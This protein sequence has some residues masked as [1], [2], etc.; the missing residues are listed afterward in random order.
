MPSQKRGDKMRNA[1]TQEA[2]RSPMRYRHGAVVTKGGKIIA[3]GHNHIRTGFSGPLSAHETIVLPKH[4]Q[5]DAHCCASYTD[6]EAPAPRPGLASSYFSMHAEM[7]AIHTILR[8][9]RP[10]LARSSVQLCPTH[11]EDVPDVLARA[12]SALALDGSRSAT[13]NQDCSR[14]S[15]ASHT[16]GRV[17]AANV[18]TKCDRALVE[19]GAGR[20]CGQW[21]GNQE[22]QRLRH[23]FQQRRAEHLERRKQE[24]RERKARGLRATSSSGSCS[25]DSTAESDSTNSGTSSSGPSTPP[26]SAQDK[27]GKPMDMS[28][29]PP[30]LLSST[31]AYRRVRATSRPRE[32]AGDSR[33]RGA[34]LYVVRLLQD[35]ESKAKAKEHRRRHQRATPAIAPRAAPAT[36]LNVVPR[37]ADSRPCWRC[38]EWM[39]WAGIKRVYWTN[40]EGEWHG[41]KVS[42]LLFGEGVASVSSSQSVLVP[43]HL[44]QYEHAAALLET[45]ASREDTRQTYDPVYPSTF[46]AQTRQDSSASLPFGRNVSGPIALDDFSADEDDMQGAPMS[47]PVYGLNAS[48]SQSRLYSPMRGRPAANQAASSSHFIVMV[49]PADLPT[50][51]LPSR[52]A[53]LASHA[54]RGILLP[55]YPTLGGQLYALAREYGLP[56]V[57]GISLYLLDDGSGNLGPR[58]SDT[59]W[60]SLWSGFFE[61]DLDESIG[62]VRSSDID[63][64][65]RPSPLPYARRFTPTSPRRRLPRVPSNASFSSTRSNSAAAY[66][67]ETGRLPIVGRFEWAVDPQRARWWTSFVTRGTDEAAQETTEPTSAPLPTRQVSGSGPR[68]LRLNQQLSPPNT[69][70]GSGR[71]LPQAPDNALNAFT[72]TRDVFDSAPMPAAPPTSFDAPG[73]RTPV[74]E[75]SAPGQTNTNA[76]GSQSV[77]MLGTPFEG[78]EPRSVTGA[79][80]PAPAFPTSLSSDSSPTLA[81]EA[82]NPWSVEN[83]RV[84]A[85]AV[86]QSSRPVPSSTAIQ[87]IAE[88]RVAT[89]TAE[90]QKPEK[91]EPTHHHYTM[92]ATVASLSA[93]ASRFFGGRGHE[94]K[95]RTTDEAPAKPKAS[96]AAED[97]PQTPTSPVHDVETARERVTEMERHSAQARRH[98]HRASVEVPRSVRRASARI[99]EV[100]GNTNRGVTTPTSPILP[101]ENALEAV[102]TGAERSDVSG[103]VDDS[104]SSSTTS[105][106]RFGRSKPTPTE[107]PTVGQHSVA[108]KS[109][110]RPPLRSTE[111]DIFGAVPKSGD[112]REMVTNLEQ[113]PPRMGHQSHP[114]LRSP[115]VLDTHLPESNETRAPEPKLDPVQLSRQS[116]IEFDNTLGDLQRALELL[117]PRQRSRTSRTAQRGSELARNNS[118]DSTQNSLAASVQSKPMSRRLFDEDNVPSQTQPGQVPSVANTGATTDGARATAGEERASLTH[119]APGATLAEAAPVGGNET[120]PH[121]L[122][123]SQDTWS[124]GTSRTSLQMPSMN[125]ADTDV[126][127]SAYTAS[128]VQPLRA[129]EPD[130]PQTSAPAS[131][132][133]MQLNQLGEFVFPDKTSGQ[134]GPPP[135]PPKDAQSALQD[136][137]QVP[138][139]PAVR[140]HDGF[141]A[142]AEDDW[143]QWSADAET[144]VP[145]LPPAPQRDTPAPAPAPAPALRVAEDTENY[146]PES[147]I[148]NSADATQYIR[149]S[150]GQYMRINEQGNI[151]E[152]D[153]WR[154]STQGQP[155]GM[156]LQPNSVQPGFPPLDTSQPSL[157]AP[158]VAQPSFAAQDVSQQSSGQGVTQGPP[159]GLPQ[160]PQGILQSMPQ[161]FPQGQPRDLPQSMPQGIPQGQPRDLPQSIPQ[162]P[163]S[164]TAPNTASNLPQPAPQAIAQDASHE[165]VGGFPQST[166]QD[167]TQPPP[168]PPSGVGAVSTQPNQMAG[169]SSPPVL[170]FP[171]NDRNAKSSDVMQAGVDRTPQSMA[172]STPQSMETD[173]FVRPDEQQRVGSVSDPRRLEAPMPNRPTASPNETSPNVGGVSS[174][175]DYDS[176][177]PTNQAQFSPNSNELPLPQ[178][179]TTPPSEP[180]VMSA[181]SPMSPNTSKPTS[182]GFSLTSRSPR[183]L[184]HSAS[185]DRLQSSPSGTSGARSFL[186]KMSPKLKWGRKKKGEDRKL[187][188]VSAPIAAMPLPPSD[189][190]MEGNAARMSNTSVSSVS[191]GNLRRSGAP[192]FDPAT[193]VSSPSLG[194][195][196]GV[197]INAHEFEPPH[198]VFRMGGA[199]ASLPTLALHDSAGDASVSQLRSPFPGSPADAENT[200]VFAPSAPDLPSPELHQS[201]L[202]AAPTGGAS[203]YPTEAPSMPASQSFS[204]DD[205]QNSV[206][207]GQSR[208]AP[209]GT[210]D[211]LVPGMAS[212]SY[213]TPDTTQNAMTLLDDQAPPKRSTGGIE[214]F[215]R[216]AP[217]DALSDAPDAPSATVGGSVYAPQG[218]STVGA[219][220]AAVTTAG[221]GERVAGA[222]DEPWASHAEHGASSLAKKIPGLDRLDRFSGG[223]AKEASSHG[224][225]VLNALTAGSF[226]KG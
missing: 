39:L 20:G 22:A 28:A 185:S 182:S 158:N 7:H 63:F 184:R 40:A 78:G 154:E 222:A 219:S 143:A 19:A 105:A 120:W 217:N 79:S 58:V 207:T 170:S 37:Y 24:K 220:G 145:G 6:E 68:P 47:A 5:N 194:G 73:Q 214:T 225:G 175:N 151:V 211:A 45:G 168:M 23:E 156:M 34:D 202:G 69:R 128:D 200:G 62:P 70:R 189:D 91:P 51:S 114:S 82:A 192:Y 109:I 204:F 141:A 88:D 17:N 89:P 147:S 27:G 43:V 180:R 142:R 205:P 161:D 113:A 107:T 116:S 210:H 56:S 125:Q 195:A 169:H 3:R 124:D 64:P 1:A 87:H 13:A 174:D 53:I 198:S 92:S 9:A 102:P 33:L 173:T 36:P 112:T 60:A 110:T 96:L 117:S 80:A 181:M 93:A 201:A 199:S 12:T 127:S 84:R 29:V 203:M 57:G 35:V 21:V 134:D 137:A 42:A 208:G 206:Y 149:V 75:A 15:D 97:K 163:V 100:I 71:S 121:T 101:A 130:T 148:R 30:A 164:N 129:A 14:L 165:F 135:P 172:E 76:V 74:T 54:R 136:T 4:A 218:A 153:V 213:N 104:Q 224:K 226:R 152:E 119:S 160:G 99:S 66:T 46:S 159:Q 55:L 171:P 190:A 155:Q 31:L 212:A 81:A 10:H 11:E 162:G 49:P 106:A 26:L 126:P 8:G 122:K 94:D 90:E 197:P 191:R 67:L 187:P 50:E 183:R 103:T 32:D 25:S 157:S 133:A 223:Q 209:D 140:A 215:G 18:K 111:G 16:T 186:A 221:T 108:R 131:V 61:D 132:P 139:N 166:T 196:E 83:G 98:A 150:E 146:V 41:G 38:L 86:P 123:Y 52:S 2:L 193:L 176:L 59:T 115:I 179:R 95:Q 144:V 85:V 77:L 177:M 178:G 118:L 138:R 72:Q 48:R 44:T 216:G 65:S 167:L 188:S